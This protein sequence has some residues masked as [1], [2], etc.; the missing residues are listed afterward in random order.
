MMKLNLN[1]ARADLEWQHG[2]KSTIKHIIDGLEKA[3]DQLD[4]I[5]DALA[6]LHAPLVLAGDLYQ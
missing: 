6:D 1:Q 3:Y 4:D 5:Q 2:S